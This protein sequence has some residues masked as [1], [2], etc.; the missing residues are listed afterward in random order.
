MDGHSDLEATHSGR[1]T[2]PSATGLD[3]GGEI[4]ASPKRHFDAIAG[5]ARVEQADDRTQEKGPIHAEIQMVH[6]MSGFVYLP[7]DLSQEG[8][9][10]LAIMDVCQGRFN[11]GQICRFSFGHFGRRFSPVMA[12]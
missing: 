6:V 1:K 8:D 12:A 9:R 5:T 7:E 3:N 2:L 11:C 10:G 4:E